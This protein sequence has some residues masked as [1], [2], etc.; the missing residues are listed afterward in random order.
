MLESGFY[1]GSKRRVE[2]TAVN[3][4]DYWYKKLLT[5]FTSACV[6]T[7]EDIFSLLFENAKVIDDGDLEGYVRDERDGALFESLHYSPERREWLAR[8][9]PV[10]GA[11][12]GNAISHVDLTY[13][14][15]E[16]GY[17]ILHDCNTKPS[18]AL[19]A[20]AAFH[21][22]YDIEAAK[23]QFPKDLLRL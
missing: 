5:S 10:V 23:L 14:Q 20:L 4:P 18:Q 12:E 2:M 16:L 19:K 17:C 1:G 6:A 9:V 11:I 3:P 21:E 13:A 22:H 15:V 7:R 8:F